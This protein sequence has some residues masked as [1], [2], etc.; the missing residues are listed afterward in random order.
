MD[1]KNKL[2]HLTD[3]KFIEKGQNVIL[4]GNP[5]TG[6]IHISIGLGIKARLEGL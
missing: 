5:G 2:N 6:K 1:T 4:S 3:L